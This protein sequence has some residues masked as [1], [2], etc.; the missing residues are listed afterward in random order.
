[1]SEI[2]ANKIQP[3]QKVNYGN[4]AESIYKKTLF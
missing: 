2:K 1:M 3:K 4:T